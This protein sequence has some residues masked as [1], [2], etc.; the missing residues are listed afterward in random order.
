[1]AAQIQG[2]GCGLTVLCLYR[3]HTSSEWW[4][5]LV[6]AL[7]AAGAFAG[8][9]V[10]LGGDFNED[11]KSE[12]WKDAFAAIGMTL[13]ASGATWRGGKR[14]GREVGGIFVSSSLAALAVGAA[15]QPGPADHEALFAQLR[16]DSPPAPPARRLA[17]TQRVALP[18]AEPER[19]K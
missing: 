5:E 1:M 3:H 18:E 17:R 8:Q 2:L 12:C 4:S 13:I 16:L 11:L 15:P 14:S 10:L 7:Q 9:H 19:D 6:A